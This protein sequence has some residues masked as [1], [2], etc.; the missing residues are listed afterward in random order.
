MGRLL[1]PA[2]RGLRARGVGADSVTLAG[3]VLG[4]AGAAAL[5]FGQFLP[6]LALILANRI[7]DGLDGEVARLDG[8][9]DRGAFLDIAFD[10]VFYAAVPLGFALADPQANALAAAILITAFV[11]TGS[12]FLAFAAIAAKRG[13]READRPPK[14]LFYLGGLTEGGET[15]AAFAAMCLWPALFPQIALGFAALCAVTTATRWRE[16]WRMFGPNAVEPAKRLDSAD[17][18]R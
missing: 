7:A 10:F 18:P 16:G 12:S 5:A 2:A 4:L 17:A 1:R 15:I 9:T 3:F 11:G 14:G 13:L 6:A 8:P